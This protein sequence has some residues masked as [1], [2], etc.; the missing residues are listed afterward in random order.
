M[1][2]EKKIVVILGAIHT[3]KMLY[4]CLGD[5]LDGSVWTSLLT[6]VVSGRVAQSLI[7]VSHK[8][9]THY[10]HQV[11]DLSLFSLLRV[12]YMDYVQLAIEDQ[13]MT[14]QEWVDHH[15]A[16]RSQFRFWHDVLEIELTVSEFVK[17]NRTGSFDLYIE[18]LIH[19]LP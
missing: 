4:D 3:E 1:S 17:A 2:L 16:A 7:G 8:T 15:S 13:P 10:I 12:V 9:R 18:S 5:W 11:T 19:L 14:F 6:E